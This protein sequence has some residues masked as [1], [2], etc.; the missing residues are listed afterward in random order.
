M[1]TQSKIK[2]LIVDDSL[3]SRTLIKRGIE[4][5][6]AIEVVAEAGDPFQARDYILEFTPD[7]MICDI[8]M[9][10][11]DGIAF[12][13]KL[14]PQYKIP[15]LVVSSD[16]TAWAEARNAGAAA[17][18]AKPESNGPSALNK[19]LVELTCRIKKVAMTNIPIPGETGL[20]APIYQAKFI[21]FGASTGGTEALFHILKSLPTTIPGI[22][23]VQHIPS[24]FSSMF[25]SRLNQLTHFIVKEAETGDKIEPGK[26]LIAPG[27]KHMKIIKEGTFFKTVCFH[28]EKVNGHR[29]SVDV[30]FDSAAKVGGSDSI[31]IILTGMGYDGAKGLLA[32]RRNG[33][34]TIGQDE[35]SSIVYGMPM[36]ANNI[37]AVEKQ[38]PLFKIPAAILSMVTQK[39]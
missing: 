14:L 7:V 34:R 5:D 30:L 16:A 13:R 15:V 24:G 37:G 22:V 12:I 38:I 19:F 25:A 28:G 32:M 21:A 36:A 23:A 31:G 20:S 39:K 8:E 6:G 26:V 3:F 17:F 10:K 9:P 1:Y 18:I 4:A 11:M 33:A 35:S 27:D 2:V 29:P